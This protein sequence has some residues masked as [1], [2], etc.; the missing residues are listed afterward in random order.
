MTKF[1]VGDVVRISPKWLDKGENP[2]QDYIVLEDLTDEV[3]EDGRVKICTQVKNMYL[4]LVSEVSYEMIY[5]IGHVD[6]TK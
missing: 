1:E 2:N 5:K 4:P 6:L 3:F